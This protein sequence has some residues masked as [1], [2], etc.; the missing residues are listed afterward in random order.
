MCKSKDLGHARH[1]LYHLI[2]SSVLFSDLGETNLSVVIFFC[3]VL[4]IILKV[5]GHLYFSFENCLFISLFTEWFFFLVFKFWSS[6]QIIDYPLCDGQDFSPFCLICHFDSGFLCCVV[7]A[8]AFVHPYVYF[9]CCWSS[10]RKLY[11]C[12]DLHTPLSTFR[13]SGLSV[14]SLIHSDYDYP[15]CLSV[16]E[17]GP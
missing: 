12:L 1:T 13:V 11:L 5:Y 3:D 15:I 2:I 14:R 9:L 7:E 16:W 10:L 6:L 8:T 4:N 17:I